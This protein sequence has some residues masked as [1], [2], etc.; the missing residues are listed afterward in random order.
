M[1]PFPN[2]GGCWCWRPPPTIPAPHLAL[3]NPK[4]SW[5]LLRLITA[6]RA[7]GQPPEG[8]ISPYQLFIQTLELLRQAVSSLKFQPNR[9]MLT[10]TEKTCVKPIWLAF[11]PIHEL[12][13]QSPAFTS[14]IF[15]RLLWIFKKF[16]FRLDL[17]SV[18]SQAWGLLLAGA[19]L[20]V[21]LPG[22]F[23]LAPGWPQAQAECAGSPWC[24]RWGSTLSSA[25]EDTGDWICV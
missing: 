24:A 18:S 22:E 14:S 4:N 1:L 19:E 8:I 15:T 2:L 20:G 11:L 6:P 3:E 25:P 23:V 12:P 16:G 7:P 10:K 21:L 9:G 13:E 5:G 17:S